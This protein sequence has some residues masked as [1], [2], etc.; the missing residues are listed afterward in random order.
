MKTTLRILTCGSVDD[1]K[2]TLIGRILQDADLAK[3]D[4]L[5]DAQ[6]V[7]AATGV[8]NHMA[9]M[10]DG[11]QEEREKGITIDVAH[12]YFETERHKYILRDCP[13]HAEFQSNMATGCSQADIAIIMIDSSRGA[14]GCVTSQTKTHFQA[15]GLF[16]LPYVFVCVNKLDLEPDA[17]KRQ[18]LFKDV[19]EQVAVLKRQWIKT[20]NVAYIPVSALT[21]ANVVHPDKEMFPWYAGDTLFDSLEN[22]KQIDDLLHDAAPTFQVVS[23]VRSPNQNEFYV[24]GKMLAGSFE[25]NS[26]LGVDGGPCELSL[27][28]IHI[29]SQDQFM[30]TNSGLSYS[31]AMEGDATVLKKG[32]ILHTEASSYFK[33]KIAERT[34]V[35]F[36]WVGDPVEGDVKLLAQ[37]HGAVGKISWTQDEPIEKGY[38]GIAV[39][40]LEDFP[41][42]RFY[43]KERHPLGAM[44]LMDPETHKTQAVATFI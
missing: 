42:Y 27:K 33:T 5:A 9:Y 30:F 14:E 25:V 40:E 22:I 6:K 23:V 36:M 26:Q 29:G 18:A 20:T 37:L 16:R 7:A 11:L 13:G 4:Q 44:V 34:T 10:C 39:V 24:Q 3:E 43:G 32:S 15:V 19:V 41:Y 31:L 8:N 35:R 28:R 2:S 38:C 17:E 21:G 1:G 12:R